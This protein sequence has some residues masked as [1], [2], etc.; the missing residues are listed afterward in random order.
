[1]YHEMNPGF[2]IPSTIVFKNSPTIEWTF[3][4][5]LYSHVRNILST[6]IHN[7]IVI[8]AI[9]HKTIPVFLQPIRLC[10]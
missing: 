5:Q 6:A 3:S 1:M 10:G 7:I 9:L 8:L 4:L 2:R